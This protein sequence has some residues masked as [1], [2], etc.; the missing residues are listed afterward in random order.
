[1]TRYLALLALRLDA[2]V[3]RLEVEA[4]CA[5]APMAERH[6]ALY[7]RLMRDAGYGRLLELAAMA[8]DLRAWQGHT[9][10]VH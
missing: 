1:M 9:G 3:T 10:R 6:P 5:P 2:V 7:A 8:P 4:G